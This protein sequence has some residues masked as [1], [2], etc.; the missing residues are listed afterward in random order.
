M[1]AFIAIAVFMAAIAA[2]AVAWPLL[3]KRESRLVGAAAGLLVMAAAAGLYPLWSNWNWHEAPAPAPGASPQVLAMVAEL[4][5]KMQ[6]APNDIKGW[7]LLGRSDI[8]LERVDDAVTAFQHAHRLDADNVEALLGLGE[9]LSMRA[10]GNITPSAGQLFERA[11]SLQPDNPRALLYSG[12]AAATR[13]DRAAARMRWVALKALNPP[14]EI[15]AMLDERIAELG[16]ADLAAAGDAPGATGAGSGS[17]GAMPGLASAATPAAAG[18]GAAAQSGA[19]ATVNLSISPALK[20][21]LT[22][23]TPLF[24]FAREPGMQGPPLAAKR[25]TSAAIGTQIHL[26]A[27]DSMVPGRVL[28]A[29][30]K[31]SITARVSFSGQPLPAAGDL[32]G[33]LTYDI[34]H[35]GVRDLVIDRV[36]Q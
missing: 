1:T 5:R 25:L 21:R 2:T 12:F 30:Q 34:G 3:R 16:T 18:Q 15:D 6:A 9:A 8:A 23:D 13:G 32:Y 4:E 7:L 35:D 33:E 17:A 28:T 36:T 20:A 31:V 26:S 11:V 10:G 24:V 14:P 22:A 29:G 27:A 19:Q